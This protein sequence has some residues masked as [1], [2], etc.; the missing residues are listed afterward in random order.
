MTFGEH[1]SEYK[2]LWKESSFWPTP[3]NEYYWE[4]VS[5]SICPLKRSTMRLPT[6]KIGCSDFV[7]QILFTFFFQGLTLKQIKYVS[8]THDKLRHRTQFKDTLSDK[9]LNKPLICANTSQG[10]ELLY[11]LKR[12]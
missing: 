2:T 10:L 4:K 3:L 12:N 11:I 6:I 1:L 7:N 8:V 9:S 5:L